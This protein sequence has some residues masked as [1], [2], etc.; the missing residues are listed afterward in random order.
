[1]I[2]TLRA[3]NEGKHR[4]ELLVKELPVKRIGTSGRMAWPLVAGYVHHL[5]K[6]RV[7]VGAGF[8]LWCRTKM[9]K[10]Q[11]DGCK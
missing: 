4:G 8:G 9:H 7:L 1:V 11:G 3:R 2:G 6:K 10:M 5:P